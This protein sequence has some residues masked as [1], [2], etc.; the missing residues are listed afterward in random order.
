VAPVRQNA[1]WLITSPPSRVISRVVRQHTLSAQFQKRILNHVFRYVAP[2]PRVQFERG[3]VL[4]Q[5]V[6]EQVRIQAV[7]ASP[8][9]DCL[10]L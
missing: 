2:L 6:A 5:E 7:S 1:S 8:V 3:G 9:V 10:S 4:V